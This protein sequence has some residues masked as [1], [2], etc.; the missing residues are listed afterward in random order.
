MS[1]NNNI[2]PVKINWNII[3]WMRG[4][5]ALYVVV[6]HSR[7]G[8]F[9]N[10]AN[11]ITH[12]APKDQWSLWEWL[13]I[14]LL[15]HTDLGTEFVILFFILSG[16]SIAHSLNNNTDYKGFY[17][18]RAIRLYPPYVLGIVW[19]IIVFI[20]IRYSA[21]KIF[22]TSI[23]NKQ[24]LHIFY[25]KFTDLRSII[26]NMLYVPKNNYLT[27]Q[28]WSLPFEVLFYLI[29]P[30]AIKKFRWYALL[31]IGIYF[32]GWLWRGYTYFDDDVDPIIPQYIIDYNVY[33]FIGIIFYSYKDYIISRFKIKPIISLGILLCVFEMLVIA[34][35]Y[36]FHQV[37]NR[38]TGIG[39]ILFSFVI[40]FTGLK[41]DIRIGWL[42]KIGAYSYTLYVTHLASIALVKLLLFKT[43]HEFY[44]IFIVYAWYY[45]IAA[46]LL[47]AYML[48]Y[49]AERPTI[50]QL[51]K[52]RIR[53]LKPA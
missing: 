31:S 11:Y 28:Y 4:L 51:E 39:M 9:T 48:Y 10:T 35:S 22:F 53:E 17:I 25:D 16:F 29:A 30:W 42:E 6:N 43:G 2:S 18:R 46:S 15:Q 32:I 12:I 52:L 45:G 3:N 36:L 26:S 23:E 33:F 20:I 8:L 13:N 47:F 24:P 44:N 14:V 21:P 40:I 49:V 41:Y 7:G 19:A 50:L 27:T 1:N 5:A 37:S 38:Y 34:K